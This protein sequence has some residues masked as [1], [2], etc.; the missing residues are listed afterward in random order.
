ML[1]VVPGATTPFRTDTASVYWALQ[2]VS[3]AVKVQLEKQLEKQLGGAVA[4]A[5]AKPLQDA[6]RGA[7]QKQLLPAFEGACQS[8]FG[9][10]HS[11]LQQGFQEHVQASAFPNP[12]PCCCGSCT[13]CD[14]A[15]VGAASCLGGL[16]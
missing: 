12:Y 10:I 1:A 15:L 3:G 14:G 11:S 4:G 13:W 2:E 6:F 7:F 16:P 9:Q 5:L 8:M